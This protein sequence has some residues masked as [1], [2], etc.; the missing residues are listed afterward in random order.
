MIRN[1]A[2]SPAPLAG[3][4]HD[5]MN[6]IEVHNT[7]PGG[8]NRQERAHRAGAPESLAQ[9]IEESG[10]VQVHTCASVHCD[11][12]GDSLDSQGL[13]V[14]FAT[15]DAALDA[16]DAAGWLV[17]PGGRLWCSACGPVLTCEAEGHQFGSWRRDASSDREHRLCVRCCLHDTRPVA[18]LTGGEPR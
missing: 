13:E 11:Q 5:G 7:R 3:G 17:G 2:T 14:H 1:I 6:P 9:A 16:A 10:M 4:E 12:C 18:S 8:R 15:E